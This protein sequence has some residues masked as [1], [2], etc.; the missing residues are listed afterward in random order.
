MTESKP[1]PLEVPEIPEAYAEP[2]V[3]SLRRLVAIV[4]RLRAPDGCPWDRAQTLETL[5]PHLIEEAFEVVEA[6]ESGTVEDMAEE[7]GDLLMGIVL[8]ARTAQQAGRFD[9]AQVATAVSEKLVRRHPHVFAEQDAPDAEA[10]LSNWEAVKREEREAKGVD[11]SALAGVP[12]AMP[13]LQRALRTAQKSMAS[14]FRWATV[15]GALDK[16]REELGELDQELRASGALELERARLEGPAAERVEAELGDL[17][18]AGAFLGAYVGIDPER[19]T[20]A[21]LRRFDARFRH[22]EAGLG[23]SFEGRPLDELLAAWER[24]KAAQAPAG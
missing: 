13:G 2:R 23:G 22:M 6:I 16:L 24:A 15:Q 20:R 18:I 1:R 9:L 12:K 14:G 7:L 11:A 21:A 3:E 8:I 5:A 4:D 17:L 10:A 19:A